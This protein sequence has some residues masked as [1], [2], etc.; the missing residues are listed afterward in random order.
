M[1]CPPRS[2]K[3][4]VLPHLGDRAFFESAKVAFAAK[5]AGAIESVGCR[6]SYKDLAEGAVSL[7]SV[8]IHACDGV[9]VGGPRDC[10][11]SSGPQVWR[12][13]RSRP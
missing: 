1:L 8:D 7:V 12:N 2:G 10:A 11:L 4:E 13:E 5:T 3:R 6:S 9:L